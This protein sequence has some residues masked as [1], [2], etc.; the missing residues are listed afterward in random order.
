MK[1]KRWNCLNF[2]LIGSILIAA[3]TL[4]AR[5]TVTNPPTGPDEFTQATRSLA[6]TPS[7][8]TANSAHPT[9]TPIDL[10]GTAAG[11]TPPTSRPTTLPAELSSPTPTIDWQAF[12]C[13]K[14]EWVPSGSAAGRDIGVALQRG[15]AGEQDFQPNFFPQIYDT[16]GRPDIY[17]LEEW[18]VVNTAFQWMEGSE[19][20]L[21]RTP[22]GYEYFDYFYVGGF[23]DEL[24]IDQQLDDIARQWPAIPPE[25]IACF[26][27]S[28]LFNQ[29]PT[30]SNV[31][32]L[33]EVDCSG[34]EW[35]DPQSEQ[36]QQ[37]GQ[38]LLSLNPHPPS[39]GEAFKRVGR[40]EKVGDWIIYQA[41]ESDLGTL[42]VL[43]PTSDGVQFFGEGWRMRSGDED[44]KDIQ[45]H[46]LERLPEAPLPLIAC[47]QPEPWLYY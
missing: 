2:L 10:P 18:V 8:T 13:P 15:I 37:I 21:H 7:P 20:V 42:Y 36:G 44:L 32:A 24:P 28:E 41:A 46:L 23:L 19:N 22:G 27:W 12:D 4:A 1:A 45:A 25:V 5:A 3:C 35:I 31:E 43:G 29:T 14:G 11:T 47:I 34:V 33:A 17:Q 40:I 30:P 38:Q 16:L 39:V 26:P 6:N 9:V